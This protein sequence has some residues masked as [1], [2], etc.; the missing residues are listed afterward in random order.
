[1]AIL[2]SLT[3]YSLNET[4]PPARKLNS[5]CHSKLTLSSIK[6]PPKLRLHIMVDSYPLS[7]G[8]RWE[9]I[10]DVFHWEHPEPSGGSRFL[11]FQWTVFVWH[12]YGFCMAALCVGVH[13]MDSPTTA[14][15]TKP[16]FSLS[17]AWA[18]CSS[19]GW[20]VNVLKRSKDHVIFLRDACHGCICMCMGMRVCTW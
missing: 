13:W 12:E 14:S 5:Y 17:V 10:T 1:M 3:V 19:N 7:T 18:S 9:L 11:V 8:W 15:G 16:L 4:Q 20:V 6:K 2:F